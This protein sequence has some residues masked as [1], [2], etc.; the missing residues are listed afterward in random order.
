MTTIGIDVGTYGTKGVAVD[1]DG[2]VLAQATAAHGMDVPRP[3]RAEHD[4]EAVW[5]GDVVRVARGL[6]GQIDPATVEGIGLSAIGPCMLPVDEAGRPL[7]P[8]VLYGVD[9]RASAQIA[10]LTAAIGEA[11]LMEVARQTLTSQSVGPKIA[12]LRD[13][14]P[15]V[16]ARTARVHTATSW[17]VERLTGEGAIDPYTASG[18]T[19]LWDAREG[20]WTDALADI[21]PLAMLPRVHPTAEVAGRLTEEAAS[22][23]GLR[24][25]TPV[26][27]GTID[28]A[29]EA[30]SV[31][32]R[33]PGDAMA[34][35]GSTVFLIALGERPAPDP[36]L[37]SAPWLA[38]GPHA[39]MGGTATSG[40]L[41]HWFRE[42][43]ARELPEGE[44]FARLAEEA[45]ASPPGARGLL[46]L[47]YFSGERT[48]INDPRARGAWFGL[49][50]THGRG[51]LYRA[52]LEGIAHGT[53]HALD[54]MAQAGAAP[55]RLSAVGGGVA[56]R[57]WLQATSDAT[58]LDQRVASVTTGASYGD[59]LL[60][61]VAVG[62]AE[63]C[64]VDRW[65]PTAELVRPGEG[66]AAM[67]RARPLWRGLYE[68][69]SDI[70][71]ALAE[72]GGE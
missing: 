10:A 7:T 46:F 40:T 36:R 55:E 38:P 32:V 56:N 65:N 44:A 19:P 11:R 25:G 72:M 2:R 20:A 61:A 63:V 17:L 62:R 52:A 16:W 58:G 66:R 24:A 8:A 51:D 4:A 12:W 53:A 27:T 28:A 30:L 35:Y 26:T 45:Q 31:G 70:M 14:R 67:E 9:T 42:R 15:E 18:F 59:A 48:P 64:D 39:S 54:A 1:R 50:L 22:A 6:A 29:A 60:A 69:T 37:W 13:E 33:R 43:L 23:T 21:L 34:M 71:A 68:R 49:D 41:T 57:V 3:G 5:W 47:P